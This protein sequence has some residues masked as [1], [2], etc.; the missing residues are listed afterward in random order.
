MSLV[1]NDGTPLLPSALTTLADN[2]CGNLYNNMYLKA[3]T[4]SISQCLQY[5][6]QASALKSRIERPQPY[7]RSMGQSAGLNEASF[8]KRLLSYTRYPPAAAAM[9]GISAHDERDVYRPYLGIATNTNAV[10]FAGATLTLTAGNGVITGGVT[11][12]GT[13]FTT[14]M[15]LGSA[16]TGGAVLPEDIIVILGVSYTVLVNTNL[17]TLTISPVPAIGAPTTTTDWF[18]VRSDMIRSPQACNSVMI[19]WQPPLGIMNHDGYLGSGQFTFIMNPDANIELNAVESKN[20]VNASGV[21]NYKFNIDEV[22]L[23]IWQQKMSIPEA[24][25]Q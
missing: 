10:A 24:L 17:T 23:I 11:V 8:Q 18:I 21:R 7:L 6:Y 14:G 5:P 12:A 1:T 4:D 2:A 3:G 16:P 22:Q 13:D 19:A 20:P 9:T 25:Q 15:P